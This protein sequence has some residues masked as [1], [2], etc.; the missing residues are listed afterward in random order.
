MAQCCGGSTRL[1]YTC[2][3]GA[4]V[5]EIADHVARK[6]RDSGYGK[7]NCL[8]GVGA[9]I[10]GFVESAKNA[11]NITID[12]CPMACGR[13]IFEHAGIACRSYVL[14]EMGLAKGKTPVTSEIVDKIVREIR[15]QSQSNPSS[16]TKNSCSC[17]G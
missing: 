7:I 9:H 11:E 6:L 1:I 4:D 8:S 12:G 3:G 10:S 17:G 15:Q 16:E 14:T 13:K 5:G 2:S